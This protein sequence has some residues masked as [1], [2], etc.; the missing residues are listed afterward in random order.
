MATKTG[1]FNKIKIER[2]T[3]GD[4]RVAK[5]VPTI[6]EF[7]SS[8]RLHREDVGNLV[9]RFCEILR[10]SA[11][12]HDWTKVR[13]PYR[14]MFYRD[15]ASVMEHGMDFFDGEWSKL[16]YY[17]LERHHLKRHCPDDVDLFD[18]IEMI[19]D[20]VAAGMARSG[21]VYDLDISEDILQKAVKNT[22]KLLKEQIEVIGGDE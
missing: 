9:G 10:V 15:M 21:D 4:T 13:E 14:S 16:H 2:N 7:N 19:C 5:H 3:N 12:D 1:Q 22:V 11:S 8:N 18:V 17:E 20:C 6:E